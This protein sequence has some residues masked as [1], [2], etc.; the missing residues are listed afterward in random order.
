M[1]SDKTRKYPAKEQ[2]TNTPSALSNVS[3][4]FQSGIAIAEKDLGFD[5]I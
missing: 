1:K 4:S 2:L 5:S 3:K